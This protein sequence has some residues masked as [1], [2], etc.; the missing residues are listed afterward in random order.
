MK[1]DVYPMGD[2]LLLAALAVA[3][4][5]SVIQCIPIFYP[6]T[7]HAVL[8]GPQPPGLWDL[9][10]SAVSAV[11]QAIPYVLGGGLLIWAVMIVTVKVNEYFQKK[12]KKEDEY[13]KVI[14]DRLTEL[15]IKTRELFARRWEFSEAV[16][17]FADEVSM[18]HM[19]IDELE[20]RLPDPNEEEPTPKPP[21]PKPADSAIKGQSAIE[22]ALNQM[23]R[24]Y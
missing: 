18:L 4:V 23:E 7:A 6:E 12:K 21:K 9:I 14:E 15:E 22:R 17:P 16:R 3:I 2:I 19:K 20:S 11:W 1:G 5:Y 8:R 10:C 13:R 24:R